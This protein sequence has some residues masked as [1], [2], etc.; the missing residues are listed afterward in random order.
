MPDHLEGENVY[1]ITL[2]NYP[3][4][5]EDTRL[6]F[7]SDSSASEADMNDFGKG[8]IDIQALD[9]SPP[10][11]PVC[12][13]RGTLI[14]T[15]NGEVPVE[16][17][18]ARDLILTASGTSVALEWI[19]HS[20][21]SLPEILMNRRISP[22][23]I[24][25]GSLGPN[26]P[27]TDL[28]VS[29]QHR[30]VLKAWNVELALGEPEVLVA[31]KNVVGESDAPSARWK[32]GVDYYHLLLDHHDIVVSNG[33]ESE[34]M[35]IGDESLRSLSVDARSELGDYLETHPDTN[36][37]AQSP[38]MAIAKSAEAIC[39]RPEPELLKSAAL[40]HAFPYLTSFTTPQPQISPV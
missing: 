20:H 33:V 12:F 9:T 14:A 36:E 31:A 10:A 26:S 38:A 25:K 22:V 13:A 23:C 32:N 4:T 16:D 30:I 19:A 40:R 6:A 1:L 3:T 17:L 7:L 27:H 8:A 37:N 34:S 24:R 15:P 2:H 11:T 5:G 28:W 18:N 39:I 35:L 21:F 29:P